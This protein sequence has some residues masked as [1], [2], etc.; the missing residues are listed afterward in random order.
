MIDKG[1]IHPV[2]GMY[3]KRVLDLANKHL[4]GSKQKDPVES[5]TQD[6]G[7][8]SE[9][10]KMVTENDHIYKKSLDTLLESKV[11]ELRPG[12]ARRFGEWMEINHPEAWS[13]SKVVLGDEVT[14]FVLETDD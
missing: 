4:E 2:T 6:F 5:N 3:L 11:L 12:K 7:S 13:S 14:T 8:N 1:K 9:R 10:I